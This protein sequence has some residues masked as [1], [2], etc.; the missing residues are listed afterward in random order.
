MTVDLAMTYN[1]DSNVPISYM[2]KEFVKTIWSL[3]IPSKQDFDGRR[4]AVWLSSQ[5]TQMT[6]PRMR[7]VE[8]LQ[9]YITIDCLGGCLNNGPRLKENGVKAASR[10]K[11]WLGF[12]KMID[13]DYVTEKFYNAYLG[14]SLGVYMG[15]SRAAA[16]SPFGNAS[17]VDGMSFANVHDFGR[18]LVNIANNYTLY[19]SYFAWRQRPPPKTLVAL[20]QF[21]QENEPLC[22]LCSFLQNNPNYTYNAGVGSLPNMYRFDESFLIQT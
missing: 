8:E 20:E 4:T 1:L 3:P 14:N 13:G 18:R 7:V 16:F 11:F 17:Y 22:R 21:S 19:A 5:C 15:S 10:Y 9:K 2:P 12:E 6:Y